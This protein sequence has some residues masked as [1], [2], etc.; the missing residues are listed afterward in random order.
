M[1]RYLLKATLN[2]RMGVG[3]YYADQIVFGVVRRPY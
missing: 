1:L 3:Y 2:H